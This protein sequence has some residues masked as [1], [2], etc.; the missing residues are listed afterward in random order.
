[1]RLVQR[2]KAGEPR[3]TAHTDAAMPATDK[4]TDATMNMCPS[5]VICKTIALRH[6]PEASPTTRTSGCLQIFLQ[7]ALHPRLHVRVHARIIV[8]LVVGR[9]LPMASAEQH[10][11]RHTTDPDDEK[12][13]QVYPDEPPF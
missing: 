10:M 1:M 5:E 8:L 3:I 12:R 13:R 7:S 2:A 9:L 4:M 6:T 11:G